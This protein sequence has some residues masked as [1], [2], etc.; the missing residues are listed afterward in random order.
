MP[1]A[2]AKLVTLP[3]RLEWNEK[4]KLYVKELDKKKP[5]IICGDMNVA[6]KEIGKYNHSQSL[7]N[8]RLFKEKRNIIFYRFNKS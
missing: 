4:F 3:K 5:V 7:I 2:G 6:H 8:I 1:N